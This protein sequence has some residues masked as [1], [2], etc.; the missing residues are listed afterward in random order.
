MPA[1]IPNEERHH[2]ETIPKVPLVRNRMR[3]KPI[4]IATD[5]IMSNQRK[6]NYL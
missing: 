4:I 5:E 2:P 1:A 3:H 6:Q